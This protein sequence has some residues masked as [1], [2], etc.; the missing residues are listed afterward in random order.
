MYT[1]VVVYTTVAVCPASSHVTLY[2]NSHGLTTLATSTTPVGSAIYSGSPSVGTA[3]QAT[4]TATSVLPSATAGSSSCPASLSGSFE[5]P[6]LIV[7]VNSSAPDQAG[8]NSF[9]GLITPTI[10]SIF[11]FDIPE[12]DAGKTCALIFLLPTK[13][14][15]ETS[16]YTLTANGM[17]TV[18]KLQSPGLESTTFNTVPAVKKAL[19]QVVE[20]GVH[21]VPEI[22]RRHRQKRD[23][24][25]N[26]RCRSS[27]VE[28]P[29]PRRKR[30]RLGASVFDDPTFAQ[31]T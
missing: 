25:A 19:G 15:L 17:I 7:H 22:G 23:A 9:N 16:A 30:G 24:P 1:T 20:V 29:V 8:G 26:A 12:D 6:H 28:A 31:L 2:S 14:Q 13:D 5:Y 11:N 18:A 4:I 27:R 3:T 21:E 10:S